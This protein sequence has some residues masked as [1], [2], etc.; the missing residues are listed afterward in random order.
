MLSLCE[1]HSSVCRSLVRLDAVDSGDCT[2]KLHASADDLVLARSG[3]MAT[4]IDDVIKELM[5]FEWARLARLHTQITFQG[6]LSLACAGGVA[7][8]SKLGGDSSVLAWAV[9][10]CQLLALVGILI[11]VGFLIRAWH[12]YVYSYMP[13]PEDLQKQFDDILK[14][15]VAA[16]KAERGSAAAARIFNKRIGRLRLQVAE[17]NHV[18]NN[19]RAAWL[20]GAR[21]WLVFTLIPLSISLSVVTLGGSKTEP[22]HTGQDVTMSDDPTEQQSP[23]DETPD[24][25]IPNLPDPLPTQD[26]KEGEVGPKPTTGA[27]E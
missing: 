21:R 25:A 13:R 2:V 9:L 23:T 12:G 10:A 15:C 5:D 20:H 3:V 7:Y 27:Q 14:A 17:R 19:E 8:V 11:Q 6:A 16:R 22:P 4:P 26:I 24:E 18:N 1:Q